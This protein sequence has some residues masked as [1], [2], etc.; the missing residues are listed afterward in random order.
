[1]INL[2]LSSPDV[3]N[4][5]HYEAL[6]PRDAGTPFFFSTG[7]VCPGFICPERVS[8]WLP[9]VPGC[10]AI[11]PTRE[12]KPCFIF[13]TSIFWAFDFSKTSQQPL[14]LQCCGPLQQVLL[15]QL[16]HKAT[17]LPRPSVGL[18]AQAHAAFGYCTCPY[19]VFLHIG[20]EVAICA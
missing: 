15:S 13:Y 2:G 5:W 11:Q 20:E 10:W 18:T 16:G 19:G 1:M 4:K 8:G 12:T 7:L 14:C 3:K 17:A 6:Q 9:A